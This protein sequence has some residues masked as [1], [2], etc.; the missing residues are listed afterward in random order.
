VQRSIQTACHAQRRC[1]CH[2]HPWRS[3]RHSSAHRQRQLMRL[4]CT[5]R[6]ACTPSWCAPAVR[7]ATPDTTRGTLPPTATSSY[8]GRAGQ[9]RRNPAQATLCSR[10]PLECR[11][12]NSHQRIAHSKLPSSITSSPALNDAVCKQR[13]RMHSTCSDKDGG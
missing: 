10:S 4:Q 12:Q 1:V 13:A 2:I 6:Q 9:H 8:S 7:A 11:T 5:D 3:R